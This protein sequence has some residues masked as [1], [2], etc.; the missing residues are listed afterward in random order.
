LALNEPASATRSLGAQAEPIGEDPS[1]RYEHERMLG[2]GAMGAV[3]LVRDRETGEQLALKKLFRMD[4]RTVLRLKR[5]FRALADL[6]HP[7]LIRVH[8][9]GRAS[10]GWY[11]T[12]EYV[13][14]EE[15][16]TYLGL[17]EGAARIEQRI[18]PAFRQLAEGILALHRAGML[19]RDLKPSNV[20]VA[21]QRVRVLDF[22]LVCEL[23]PKAASLTEEGAINGTP[24]YMAPE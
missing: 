20:M 22:G 5:E 1:V 12:M 11:L 17:Q 18:V 15:L 4:A 9:L 3:S 16:R 14:G 8:E 10:D 24:A 2:E 6:S 21:N 23:D 7:N 19:H 13:A